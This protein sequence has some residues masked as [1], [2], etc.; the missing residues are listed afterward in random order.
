LLDDFGVIPGRT[1]DRVKVEKPS[2]LGGAMSARQAIFLSSIE[3]YYGFVLALVTTIVISR[4]LKP[5]EVGLFSIA[6]SVAGVAYVLREFGASNFLIRAPTLEARHESCAFGMTLVLGMVLGVLLLLL[7]Y[8]IALFFAHPEIATL[9]SILSI[10]FFLLPFGVVNFALIQRAMRFDLSARIGMIAASLSA[11]VSMGL[12]WRGYGAFSLAW[13][14]VTL[15]VAT[16]GM[17]IIWGPGKLLVRPQLRGASELLSFGYKTTFL[18]MLWEIGKHFP[19]FAAGRLL[20]FSAAGLLSRAGGLVGNVSDLLQRGLQPV[21]LPHFARIEREGGDSAQAHY[22][23]VAWMTGIG[24]PICAILVVAA[25]PLV[26]LFY[27]SQW[28]GAVRPLQILCISMAYSFLFSY[29][30]QVVMVKNELNAEIRL[31]LGLF[32][33][34]LVL[35]GIGASMGIA[36]TC[37][38]LLLSDVLATAA[39]A[40]VLFPRIGVSVR[41]YLKIAWIGLPSSVSTLVG[42]MA[43]SRLADGMHVGNFLKCGVIGVSGVLFGLTALALTAHPVKIEMAAYLRSKRWFRS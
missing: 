25:E 39:G 20:G 6:M 2:S 21:T 12:A 41:E 17:T 10:N 40:V 19:E 3:R 5:A 14:A 36:A 35:V 23:I 38:A 4:L 32:P 43:G 18:T 1:P 37:A 24:W 7:A 28:Q 8:P 42:A 33:A 30:Y 34:R 31:A 29:Q 22:Q 15:T 9:L 27:G 13:G 16:A 26:M 11:A